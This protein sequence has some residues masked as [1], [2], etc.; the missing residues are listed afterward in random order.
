[1][2]AIVLL[3]LNADA[4][5]AT[6]ILEALLAAGLDAR[7]LSVD[8]SADDFAKAR[9]AASLARCVLFCWSE[10]SRGDAAA[11]YRELARA[12]VADGTAVGVELDSGAAPPDL[13]MASYALQGWRR[14]E[15]GL[16][17]QLV[18]SVFYNDIVAAAKFKAAGR[19]PAPP[20]AT[21]KLLMRQLWVLAVG[22]AGVAGVLALPAKLVEQIPWPRWNEESAWAA[23]PPGSCP[24]LAAFRQQYPAGRYAEQA[25]AIFENRLRGEVRLV[26]RNRPLPFF[27]GAADAAPAT[28]EAAARAAAATRAGDERQ[29]ICAGL[30]ATSEGRLLSADAVDEAISCQPLGGGFVC[31]VSGTAQCRIEEKQADDTER[32]FKPKT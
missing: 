17:R 1:M 12:A 30:A 31:S 3:S 19:D 5:R 13:A 11:P 21:T 8:R 32:C 28:S 23:L 20:S 18:G 24:A 16:V 27:V 9:D 22:A 2:T 4:A 6:K 15:G 29:K 25:T 7:W 26:A 10:A 14:A